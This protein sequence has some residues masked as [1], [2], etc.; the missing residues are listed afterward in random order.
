MIEPATFLCKGSN[1]NPGGGPPARAPPCGVYMEQD[2]YK[3]TLT[4]ARGNGAAGSRA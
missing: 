2:C 1:L 4:H 3:S